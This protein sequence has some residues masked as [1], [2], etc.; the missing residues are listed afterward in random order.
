LGAICE[1][2]DVRKNWRST[3]FKL[4]HMSRTKP[5]WDLRGAF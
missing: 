5:F 2:R 3:F 4:G 1:I